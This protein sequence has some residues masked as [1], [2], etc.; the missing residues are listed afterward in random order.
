MTTYNQAGEPVQ[1]AYAHAD[2]ARAARRN[3]RDAGVSGVPSRGGDPVETRPMG[4]TQKAIIESVLAREI[5]DSRGNPDRR[6]RRRAGV[7]RDRHRRRPVG[8]VDRRARGAG[9]ARRR[10]EALPRQGRAQGVR[11]R[12]QDAG[13]GG[14]RARRL[15]PGRARRGDAR[16]RRHAQQG[17]G[18]RQRDAGRL[19]GGGARGRG[20]A[21]AA[22]L[23]VPGR[24]GG[25]RAAGAA[26]EHHQRRR[27]RRQLAR[28]PGVHDRPQGAAE[29]LGGA[30]RRRRGVPH[31]QEAAPRS[32]GVDGRRRRGRLRAR[33]ARRR[34]GAGA[35]SSRRSRRPATSR[36]R[37]SP[38]P[39]TSRRASCGTR[40]SKTY[41]LEGEGKE[42]DGKRDWSASTGSCASSSR[43]CRSRTAWPRTTG[44]AGWR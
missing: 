17:Q 9:A 6:G 5:L 1:I 27:P 8:R 11:Q 21:R 3:E 10:Q 36:A 30:A 14:R 43:S 16:G 42:L 24:A 15:R 12:R 4:F 25:A 28:L 41:K 37:T 7:R 34:G 23:Q 38:W 18:R 31:P 26:D 35:S 20:R 44:T 2:R 33:P 39:S 19:D 13:A 40:T 32:Q 29:L 22:A